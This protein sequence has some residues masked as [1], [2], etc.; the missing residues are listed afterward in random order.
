MTSNL[1][2]WNKAKITRASQ[3]VAQAKKLSANRSR[4][5]AVSAATGVPWDVIAVIHM[6]ESSADFKGVLHNGQ[7]II[8]TG[9]K[10][11]IVPKG[12]GPFNTWE[13]A[14][15]DALM[16]CAPYLGKNKD[17][18]LGNTLDLLE[19]Y[20]GL[21]YQK[22]GL[23]SP[24]LWAGTDQYV[25][26]KYVADGKFDANAVDK[27]LGVVPLMMTLRDKNAPVKVEV[28]TNIYDGKYHKEIYEVQVLLDKKKYPEV[29]DTD[30]KYGSKTATAIMAFRRENGLPISDK[31]DP[32]FLSALAVAPDRVIDEK[33]ANATVSDLRKEEVVEI[34]Q[35]DQTKLV[36]Q[37]TTGLGGLMGGKKLLEEFQSQS[38]TIRSI[39]ETIQPI[40]SFVQ[41]N[42]WL[43]LGGVG[44]FVVWKSGV[45]Q[46]IRL[47]K[48]QEGQDV[49]A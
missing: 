16:K 40:Y 43:I 37:V 26:G 41:D 34:K 45:L 12:R 17:W 35:T 42:I 24:Y 10:T 29:G 15:I 39:V 36:G 38:D 25:K 8:G 2:R 11:T 9:K 4:Y 48:H 27:Q 3:V 7:K 5:E 32:T 21:G 22:K 20:N 44:A 46:R 31:I 18:S 47:F 13:E 28:P 6:R 30:G 14:G 33:R 1:D 23:P 19:K 49:S